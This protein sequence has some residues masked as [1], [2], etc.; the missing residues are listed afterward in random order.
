MICQESHWQQED[1]EDPIKMLEK[2]LVTSVR[3]LRR[4]DWKAL[5]YSDFP[6]MLKDQILEKLK[7]IVPPARLPTNASYQMSGEKAKMVH[8]QGAD[9]TFTFIEHQDDSA[10]S[11]KNGIMNGMNVSGNVNVNSSHFNGGDGK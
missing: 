4:V 10:N 2:N 7:V 8:S 9:A 6:E 3:L 11:N 1:V 5:K